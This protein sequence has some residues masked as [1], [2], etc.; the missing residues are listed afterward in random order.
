MK[1]VLVLLSLLNSI[2][3]SQVYM[4]INKTDGTIQS[5]NIEEIRKLTFSNVVGIQEGKIIGNAITSFSLL[6]NYPNPFNPTTTIEYY[7]P[8]AGEVEVNVFN[9]YGQLVKS[10]KSS[11]QNPGVH[12]FTWDSQDNSGHMVSSGIYLIHLQYGNKL[13]TKKMMLIK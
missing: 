2:G 10:I 9:I 1:S 8:E 3:L 12:K 4:N 13:L 6:R 5:Y 11:F 7:L